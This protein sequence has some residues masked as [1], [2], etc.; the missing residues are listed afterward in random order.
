MTW[1]RHSRPWIIAGLL[2]AS[3]TLT[4]GGQ[5]PP[6]AQTPPPAMAS[7]LRSGAP[8][9]GAPGLVTSGTQGRTLI[10]QAQAY[11][12]E[13]RLSEAKEAL[14]TAIRLEPMNLEAWG[15]YDYCVETYYVGRAREEKVNPVIE[16]D[17]Q[18]LFNFIR[19]ESYQEFGTVYIVGE[20]KNISGSLKSK[21]ELTGTLL[22][23]QKN[24]LRKTSTSLSLKERG[25]FPNETSLFEIP[26]NDPPPG[27]KSYRVRV[28]SFE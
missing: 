14:R 22:D 2:L 8:V 13:G 17:L 11:M 9:K 15:L 25:L 3:L 5:N 10:T 20:V 27:V 18:P 28:S 4:V 1:F 16:R 24:E 21:I 7:T 26:F 6:A 23:D 19:V 12:A